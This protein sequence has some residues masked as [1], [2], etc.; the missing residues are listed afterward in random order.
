MFAVPAQEYLSCFAMK[1]Q[2]KARITA[3]PGRVR[4]LNCRKKARERR[5]SLLKRDEFRA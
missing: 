4:L 3:S 1:M 2:K 5:V